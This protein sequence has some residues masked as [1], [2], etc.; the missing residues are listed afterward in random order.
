MSDREV[1]PQCLPTLP[2]GRTSSPHYK[3]LKLKKTIDFSLLGE[4]ESE[5]VR[6]RD[7]VMDLD[8]D[9]SEETSP[10]PPALKLTRVNMSSSRSSS[11]YSPPCS[12]PLSRLGQFLCSP[13]PPQAASRGSRLF[14][15]PARKS[16]SHLGAEKCQ[17][18]TLGRRSVGKLQGS[19]NTN[20][21]TPLADS[22][23]KNR[24]RQFY[25]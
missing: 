10:S 20:P 23:A 5:D 14:S 9:L 16:L 8:D 7:G 18:S 22:Q 2:P 19:V 21:F 24:K 11:V 15:R 1:T 13:S 6:D 4:D 3:M 12:T 17:S 25:R